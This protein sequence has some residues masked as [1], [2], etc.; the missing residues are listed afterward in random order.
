MLT[1]PLLPAVET[2]WPFDCLTSAEDLGLRRVD[3]EDAGPACCLYLLGPG[4][5]GRLCEAG[6]LEGGATG[7]EVYAEGS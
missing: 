3:E 7:G 2:A 1:L 4:G 5:G 6:G